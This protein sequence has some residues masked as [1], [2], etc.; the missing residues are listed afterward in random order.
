MFPFSVMS[1][2]EDEEREERD[3]CQPDQTLPEAHTE[4]TGVS[5][6]L[7]LRGPD[8]SQRLKRCCV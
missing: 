4:V 2:N 1:V 3:N 6:D 7:T 5:G 8:E